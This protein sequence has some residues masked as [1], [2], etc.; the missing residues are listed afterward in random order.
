MMAKQSKKTTVNKRSANIYLKHLRESS[1][2]PRVNLDNPEM[3]RQ[4]IELYF[5]KC[6]QDNIPITLAGL[7]S[8]LKVTQ[9]TL[10][11]I[12]SGLIRDGT[13]TQKYV[14]DA[15]DF[16]RAFYEISMY[17]GTLPS[18]SGIFLGKNNLGYE[19]KSV[20]EVVRK[21]PLGDVGDVNQLRAKYIE[22]I[23]L[24]PIQPIGLL[25]EISVDNTE[26][27]E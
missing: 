26:N 19:D 18:V 5:N 4:R 23:D 8:S 20:Q 25:E 21:N 12:E 6:E 16:I 1:D 7:S 17:D 24:E 10:K 3:L 13:L 22:A 15:M 9:K 27:K 2:L 11:E 14:R